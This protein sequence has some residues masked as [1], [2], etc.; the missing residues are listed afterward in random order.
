MLDNFS[1]W[2]YP[3]RILNAVTLAVCARVDGAALESSL[4]N[5]EA[6]FN[7]KAVAFNYVGKDVSSTKIRTLLALGEKPEGI[8]KQVYDY[9]KGNNIY[10]L[11]RIAEVK[12]ML[13]EK[14]WRHTVGVC[15]MAAQNCARLNVPESKAITAAALHDCAKYLTA[16]SPLLKGFE[17]EKGV[18]EQVIHQFSGAFVAERHFGVTDKDILNAIKY[19]TSGRAEMSDLEKLIYL[20][21]MLEGSRNFDGVEELRQIFKQDIDKCLFAALKHQIEYLNSSGEKIYPLTE[22]AYLYLKGKKYDE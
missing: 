1:A 3:E 12:S 21:D 18:P 8:N 4:K 5:F 2:K 9:I 10:E 20:C 17:C 6:K 19:H 7:K 15:L 11:P 16:D 22:Q 13:T 14:R